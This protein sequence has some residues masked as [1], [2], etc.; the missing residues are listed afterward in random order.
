MNVRS[1]ILCNN[2]PPSNNSFNNRINTQ[3]RPGYNWNI[4]KLEK[5]YI[6]LAHAVCKFN[7]LTTIKAHGIVPKGH[8]IK[9][10]YA[11]YKANTITDWALR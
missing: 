6:Q 11:C 2:N 3:Y 10:P 4:R 1:A 5:L 8:C 9:A 7:F